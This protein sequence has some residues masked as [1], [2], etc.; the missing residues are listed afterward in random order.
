[1][2]RLQSGI[3]QAISEF[4]GNDDLGYRVIASF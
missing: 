2:I 3:G 1:M 4:L